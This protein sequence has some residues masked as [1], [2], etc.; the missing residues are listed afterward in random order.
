MRHQQTDK[1]EVER[2]GPGTTNHH[3]DESWG[4]NRIRSKTPLLGAC[5]GGAGALSDQQLIIDPLCY[6][7]NFKRSVRT[8]LGVVGGIF[9]LLIT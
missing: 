9:I 6:F 3:P 5:D 2:P 4:S 1:N 8:G 7:L